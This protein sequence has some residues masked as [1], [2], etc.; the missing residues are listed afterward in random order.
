MSNLL[1]ILAAATGQ[2]PADLAKGYTQYGPLKADA[3]DA[4][5]ELLTPVQE[6]YRELLADRG[7]LARL[8]RSGSDKARHVASATLARAYDAIGFVKA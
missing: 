8:L 4:V 3:G 5:I 2:A 1:E 6:R 7:E